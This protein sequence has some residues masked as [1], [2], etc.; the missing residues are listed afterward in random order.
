MLTPTVLS[1]RQHPTIA[2]LISVLFSVT[3]HTETPTAA[4]TIQ[5]EQPTLEMVECL[6]LT[7][8]WEA[9]GE[10]HAGIVAVG[11]VVLNRLSHPEFPATICQVVRQGGKQP[12]CQFA[13]WCDGKSDT[14]SDP[15][16]WTRVRSIAR[17]IITLGLPDPTGGALF[18]HSASLENIP[19][20]VTRQRT[21]QIGNQIYYR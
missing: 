9:G 6:A 8:Y 17:D 12:G 16:L 15:E 21:T 14:P 5:P 1:S 4:L 19:W 20:T 13:Y 3:V 10:S 2:L 11:W 18:F 7:L